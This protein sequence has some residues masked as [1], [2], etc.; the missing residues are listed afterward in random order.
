MY[1]G[2]ATRSA[3]RFGRSCCCPSFSTA[4]PLPAHCQA[5]AGLERTWPAHRAGRHDRVPVAPGTVVRAVSRRHIGTGDQTANWL[6]VGRTTGRGKTSATHAAPLAAKDVWPS[7]LGPDFRRRLADP[8]PRWTGHRMVTNLGDSALSGSQWTVSPQ[9]L[10]RRF[11]MPRC[12]G[13]TPRRALERA[14]F[15]RCLARR[16]HRW[17][18]PGA[19]RLNNGSAWPA[20]AQMAA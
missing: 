13:C 17:W 16:G 6:L 20:Q 10:Q 2:R 11:S 14:G 3:C 5:A 7:L 9:V 19:C 12:R 8:L 4:S 18:R 15:P 1:C